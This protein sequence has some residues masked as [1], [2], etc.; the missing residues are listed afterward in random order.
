MANK[1]KLLEVSLD[2]CKMILQ[3]S[4]TASHTNIEDI[5][6]YLLSLYDINDIDVNYSE[7][8]IGQVIPAAVHIDRCML[9]RNVCE[10]MILSFTTAQ[11][12]YNIGHSTLS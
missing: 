3:L 8:D 5:A 12:R 1:P 10:L 11:R 9:A 4:T 7:L 6:Y 2:V